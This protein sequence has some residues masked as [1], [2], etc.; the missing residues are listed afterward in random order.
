MDREDWVAEAER[1]LGRMRNTNDPKELARIRAV[2]NFLMQREL[3][4][5]LRML[6][7]Q[8]AELRRPPHT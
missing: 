5:Q 1:V 3:V 6:S 4:Y 7:A 2:A 8:V